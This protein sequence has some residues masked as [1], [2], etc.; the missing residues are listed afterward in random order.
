MI[1]VT[2][3]LSVIL[4]SVFTTVANF[5][6]KSKSNTLFVYILAVLGDPPLL[7]TLGA[8]LLFNMKEAGAKGL[9]EGTSCGS[10]ST[11]SDIEFDAPPEAAASQSHDE[12]TEGEII[13]IEETC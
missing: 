9:N 11:I 4:V 3:I 7:S 5:L 6:N 10:K 13:E 2:P 8:R 12:A 1:D